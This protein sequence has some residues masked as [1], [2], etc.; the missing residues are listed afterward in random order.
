MPYDELKPLY[1]PK[2]GSDIYT[3]KLRITSLGKQDFIENTV[4]D[5]ET[6][7]SENDWVESFDM[8]TIWVNCIKCRYCDVIEYET[9]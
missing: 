9:M 8:L 5:G 6:E 3:V 1:C 2:C 4:T 7:F